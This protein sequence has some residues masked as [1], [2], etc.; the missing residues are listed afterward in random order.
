MTWEAWATLAVVVLTIWALARNLAS[1]EAVLLSSLVVLTVLGLFSDH[2]LSP[3]E[4]A[5]VFGNEALVAIG[6]LLIVGAGLT[7]TGGMGLVV[8]RLLGRPKRTVDAQ[9]RLLFPV[10]TAS[11]FMNN[12][13]VVA[14]FLPV[15][16][17]WC[18][19]S[20]LNAAKL[21]I[22][23]SYGAIF[24]GVCT[25]IGTSTNLT[26]QGMLIEA[27][28]PPLGMFTISAVGVPVAL[29]GAG[30]TILT[31]RWLL[32]AR[33]ST[34][35]DLADPRQYTVEMLV[36]GGSGLDGRTIEEAGLRHLPGLYLAHIER[37]GETLVAVGPEQR[38]H[39]NDRL[40]FVGVVSS[41][42]DLQRIRGLRPATD[43]VFK[44]S[45]PRP[46][47]C[48]IEAVV[49]S[50]CPLVGRSIR[51]GRFRGRYDAAVIAVHRNGE[52]IAAKVGDIVL[53][54][55]D[56]LLLEGHPRFYQAHQN[57]RDFYLVSPVPD[58]QPLRHER[59]P[60]ALAILTAMVLVVAAEDYTHVELLPGAL[61][62]AA[63]MVLTRCLSFEQAMRALD[64]R[65][66]LMIG[67]S[68]GMG[69]A[70]ESSRAAAA[71]S[72]QLT[73]LLQPLGP[74]AVLAGIYLLTLLLTE[75]L[76]NNAAAV[77]SFPLARAAAAQLGVD[78]TPFAICIAIAASAGFAIPMGY[79]THLMV[80]GPGGYRFSDFLRIGVPLDIF[81]MIATVAVTPLV[82]PFK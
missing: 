56:T 39:A 9:V 11:A 68:L 73:G 41:V 66:L 25:L 2:L 43:Q 15:V 1:S 78:F 30:F 58:S 77:L 52:R 24:G 46:D 72:Q 4:V 37:G 18:S 8:E 26:V 50:S 76:S 48:L 51:A 42:V 82:F 67:A 57:S 63:L 81:V 69:R 27:Q 64:W 12:T 53:Q 44:L 36:E 70:F 38:L 21:L 7:E 29:M 6:A 71:I 34:E 17:E 22:P 5:Q 47:R 10:M 60:I 75:A 31:A 45:G 19:R 28:L 16:R 49:S 40:V 74:L 65:M 59:A 55:G 33:T 62:A 79:Q 80:Y 23:L 3:R 13:T 35:A 32:P 61:A 20:G 14:M 54:P